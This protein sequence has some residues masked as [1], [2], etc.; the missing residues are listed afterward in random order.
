LRRF[1]GWNCYLVGFPHVFAETC[2]FRKL[3]AYDQSNSLNIHVALD[4]TVVIDEIKA[5][6][7]R[8]QDGWQAL[9]L[10][11]PLRLGLTETNP[12][13]FHDLKVRNIVFALFD[14]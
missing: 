5:E 11:V 7:K 1:S 10:V 6:C 9:L 8:K 14:T 2:S 4:N 12:I 13:Y 3:T